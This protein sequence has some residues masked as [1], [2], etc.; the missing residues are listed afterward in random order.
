MQA[1]MYNKCQNF[2]SNH[3]D[4]DC[5]AVFIPLSIV[6]LP[7]IQYLI[8]SSLNSHSSIFI[9][10]ENWVIL[11]HCLTVGNLPRTPCMPGCCSSIGPSNTADN[12]SNIAWCG[13]FFINSVVYWYFLSIKCRHKRG[14]FTYERHGSPCHWS[15]S[16]AGPP[17]GLR[18]LRSFPTLRTIS[19]NLHYYTNYPKFYRLF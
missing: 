3:L 10:F 4:N 9:K 14:Q 13:N 16:R 1:T 19:S 12:S 11:G 7:E 8:P 18:S 6:R 17:W 15:R 5:Q 2:H